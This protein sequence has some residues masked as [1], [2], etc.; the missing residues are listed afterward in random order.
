MPD[1]EEEKKVV[2]PTE[3]DGNPET[4]EVVDQ[5]KVDDALTAMLMDILGQIANLTEKVDKLVPA[6]APEEP[7]SEPPGDEPPAEEEPS[8][9]EVAEIDKLLQSE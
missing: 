4:V 3:E 6:E 5:P 1:E 7:V 9:D 2:T 8:E